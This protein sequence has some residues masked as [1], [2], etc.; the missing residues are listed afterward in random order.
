MTTHQMEDEL[1]Q[2]SLCIPSASFDER[3]ALGVTAFECM[4]ADGII[5]HIEHEKRSAG[6]RKK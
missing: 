3:N 4:A 6:K 5:P 1:Y 2:F